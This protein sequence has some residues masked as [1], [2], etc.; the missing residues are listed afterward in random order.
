MTILELIKKLDSYK[1]G[2]TKKS[3]MMQKQQVNY[4]NQYITVIR[5]DS[6]NKWLPSM[7]MEK[8]WSIV[9]EKHKDFSH[10]ANYQ[11]LISKYNIKITPV[12][13]G[14]NTGCYGLRVYGM[15]KDPDLQIITDILDFI[16]K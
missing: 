12:R 7:E 2:Q 9:F 1:T 14:K 16:F 5:I 15:K 8:Q 10:L 4:S 3:W 13:T 6:S 11:S